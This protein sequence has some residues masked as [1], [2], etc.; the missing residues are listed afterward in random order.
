MHGFKWVYEELMTTFSD[1]I[2]SI[3]EIPSN[4]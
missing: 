3:S 4:F 1:Y 2:D